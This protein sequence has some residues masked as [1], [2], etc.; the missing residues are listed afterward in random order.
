M[1]DAPTTLL[2][3]VTNFVAFGS[4]FCGKIKILIA[5]I[6]L[7][8][9][10]YFFVAENLEWFSLINHNKRNINKF[11]TPCLGSLQQHVPTNHLV[12]S[13]VFHPFF[14]ATCIIHCLGSFI[15][16]FCNVAQLN[17]HISLI[18]G[19]YKK[20]LIFLNTHFISHCG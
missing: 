14:V 10:S 3:Y 6:F 11:I 5:T 13:I 16:S 8:F 2:N 9:L 17:D 7:Y 20:S 18:K 12:R 15:E 4:K 19:Y 1:K